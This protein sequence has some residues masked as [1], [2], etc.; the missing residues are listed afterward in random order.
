M[1]TVVPFQT[2]AR[3]KTSFTSNFRYGPLPLIA[4]EYKT[5]SKSVR[6]AL[7]QFVA[8]DLVK[9][10]ADDD[11][12]RIER[13]RFLLA[14]LP[15]S[16]DAVRRLLKRPNAPILKE[17]HFSLFC[18]LPEVTEVKA[19]S[20]FIKRVPILVRNYLLH[21]RD[22]R[23]L[24]AWM[25]ADLIGDHWTKH[26]GLRVLTEVLDRGRFAPARLAALHGIRVLFP[27]LTRA[28]QMMIRKAL[29][30]ATTGDASLTVR[31][32]A[33]A[34]LEQLPALLIKARR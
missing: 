28:E 3:I 26:A 33:A 9:H 27:R 1:V 19:A 10:H 32:G 15:E 2:W 8:R 23:A 21:V 11:D 29:H 16:G 25:A 12:G 30:R 6:L 22:D 17:I 18:F 14:A 13:V 5:R 4:S 31:R 7:V 20:A 34:L 24:A